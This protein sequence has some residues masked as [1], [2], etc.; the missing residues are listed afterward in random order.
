[1][2]NLIDTIQDALVNA[3]YL[4]GDSQEVTTRT[5]GAESQ[6]AYVTA[7]KAVMNEVASHRQIQEATRHQPTS[8]DAVFLSLLNPPVKEKPPAKK[9]T[10]PKKTPR[11]RPAKKAVTKAKVTKKKTARPKVV[12]KGKTTVK[13]KDYLLPKKKVETASKPEPKETE[14]EEPK[15][16]E[17]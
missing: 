15:K 8:V 11:K 2:E 6:S 5:W 13:S 17:E 16:T 7:Y 4:N 10:A 14:T 9:K 3:G 1:M 12:A